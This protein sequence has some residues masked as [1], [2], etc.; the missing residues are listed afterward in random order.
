[1][2]TLVYEGIGLSP[3]S[4]QRLSHI[5]PSG[6]NHSISL[7]RSHGQLGKQGKGETTWRDQVFVLWKLGVPVIGVG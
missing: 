3:G 7:E 1:M 5:K 6:A 2:G 4:L